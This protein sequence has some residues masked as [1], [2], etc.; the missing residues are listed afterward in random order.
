MVDVAEHVYDDDPAR[1]HPDVRTRLAGVNYFL[2]GNGLIQAAV[3]HAPRGEGT[4]LGLLIMD[5]D[6]LRKKRDALTMHPAF[7][8][9]TSVVHLVT[10]TSD[11]SPLLSALAVAWQPDAP[12]PTVVASWGA[13]GFTVQERFYCPSASRA[14]LAREVTITN[15]STELQ[16]GWLRTSVPDSTVMPR[17]FVK[18]G[19]RMRVWL[20]YDL[21]AATGGLRLTAAATDPTEAD[22]HTAWAGLADVRFDEPALDHLFRASRAQLPA[23]V[24]A[25]GRLDGSIWQYNREWV[26]DQACI[27][28][29]LTQLG[30]RR[31]AVTMLRRLATEFVTA[32]GATLDSSEVRSRDDVELDQNGVLLYVLGEYVAWTGDVA[33]VADLWDRIVAIAEYPLRPEFRHGP[34]GMLSG[35]RE[36]WER[37]AAHGI[38]PG[39]EMVYQMFVSLGLASAAR[40]ARQLGREPEAQ[41]W[42]ASAGG[43]R[44]AMGAHP[45][46][47][48]CDARGIIKRRTLEGPVQETISASPG[49]GL[50]SGVPLASEQ[51]HLLNPDTCCVLP[52]AFGMVDAGAPV[53]LATLAAIE[54]LWNQAW[55]GGGYGRYHVSSEPDSPGAW[56][57]ASVFVARA[58]VE[59]GDSA[60]VW[61]ILRWLAAT[62]GSASGAWFEFNGPRIAPPF[63]QVGIIPWTWAELVLLL[64]HHVLGVR[65][66]ADGIRV[67]PR[68]LAGMR[69]VDARIPVRDGWLRLEL[70]ADPTAPAESS[71]LIPYQTGDMTL[72]ARVRTLP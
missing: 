18:P 17:I 13:R 49:S 56:P 31:V 43:L 65:P 15:R 26:R 41:R 52:I 20:V 27:A 40:L 69:G 14:R 71:F 28:L 42:E 70:R 37:H 11:V 36:F 9:E 5:P 62:H 34:S 63:P 64:I 66:D 30:C 39:L 59:A 2:L 21:D 4:A 32:E 72:V 44:D 22:A 23:A 33:L 61:R 10:S 8:L 6:R 48:L 68:L 35:S 55:E 38:E 25:R 46:Y 54:S 45:I 16:V 3:Q 1:G 47:A 19:A 7:G 60:R 58:L 12:V 53:S 29:A 57:F 67:R 51:P 24:S 50:P